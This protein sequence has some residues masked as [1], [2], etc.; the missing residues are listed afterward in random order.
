M[1][2][3]EWNRL[4]PAPVTFYLT[5]PQLYELIPD[6]SMASLYWKY[7]LWIYAVWPGTAS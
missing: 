4:R 5:N 6:S 1:R 3:L 7:I 2:G